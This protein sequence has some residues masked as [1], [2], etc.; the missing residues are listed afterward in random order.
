MLELLEMN[1]LFPKKPVFTKEELLRFSNIFDNAGQVFLAG[2][3]ITPFFSEIDIPRIVVI[4]LGLI[5]TFGCWFTSWR[6]T[7]KTGEL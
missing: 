3:V 7:K 2:L 1:W 4:T 6:L 5:F